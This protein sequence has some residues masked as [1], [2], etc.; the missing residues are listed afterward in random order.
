LPAYELIYILDPALTEEQLSESVQRFVQ[1]AK[2]QGAEVDEPQRWPK[3]RLAYPIKGKGEGFYVIMMLRAEAL[4]MAELTRV[5]KLAE[6][7]LRHMVV[8]PEEKPRPAHRSRPA[9]GAEPGVQ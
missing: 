4:A 5:L 1:V 6:P 2:D 9:Q 7:V 3:R 8:A